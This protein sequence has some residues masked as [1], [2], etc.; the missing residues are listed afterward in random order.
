M[1]KLLT[2]S[3]LTL[4]N[5]IYLQLVSAIVLFLVLLGLAHAEEMDSIL[6]VDMAEHQDR[7]DYYITDMD[8]HSSGLP[9]NDLRFKSA[10]ELA[11][12]E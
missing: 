6:Q 7:E 4:C 9:I 8:I 5:G 3:F 1:F 2:S 12:S 10:S 11:S